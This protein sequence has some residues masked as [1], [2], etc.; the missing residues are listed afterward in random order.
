MKYKIV[1]RTEYAYDKFVSQCHNEARLLPRDF[2]RQQCS[3]A[4]LTITPTPSDYSERED[5]FGNRVAHFT[6]NQSHR[7]LVV[8]AS[9]LVEV[10]SGNRQLDIST[11][12]PWDRLPERLHAGSNPEHL[13]ARQYLL[14]SPLVTSTQDLADYAQPS[15]KPNRSLLEAVHDLMERI[16][17]D[18]TY[19]PGFTTLSTPLAEVLRHRR[20]VCQDFAHLAIGCLRAQGV[21]TRYISGYLET[22]PPPGTERL[23]GADASHAWFSVYL[24]DNGW[25][26]FDP[27]NNQMPMDRHITVA[28]GRDYSDVSPLKGVVFGGGAHKVS[29][30][31]DVCNLAG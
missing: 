14:D 11:D 25:L 24:P 23:V 31:V 13:F 28:W 8:T 1:H 21:P 9:S 27:T 15:F 29:V 17:R 4:Q 12:Q 20:G 26:D 18:F 6:V 30:S 16:H 19:D 3:D 10:E 5:F 7:N 22:I 2:A